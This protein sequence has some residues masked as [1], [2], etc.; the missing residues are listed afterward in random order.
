MQGN[1]NEQFTY[2]DFLEFEYFMTDM[3]MGLLL[4]A[5][6]QDIIS[7]GKWAQDTLS[8]LQ[9][10]EVKRIAAKYLSINNIDELKQAIARF[11]PTNNFQNEKEVMYTAE[12]IQVMNESAE[13]IAENLE[14]ELGKSLLECVRKLT[15]QAIEMSVGIDDNNELYGLVRAIGKK[16]TG[17]EVKHLTNTESVVELLK[18]IYIP[19]NLDKEKGSI[20]FVGS[21]LD[22]SGHCL[23]RVKSS[24]DPHPGQ[25]F[26]V[27]K[28][29][30]PETCNDD[31][32]GAKSSHN[33]FDTPINAQ[34]L[35][36][37]PAGV[38]GIITDP[39]RQPAAS[40]AAYASSRVNAKDREHIYVMYK[41]GGYAGMFYIKCKAGNSACIGACNSKEAILQ[42]T[43]AGRFIQTNLLPEG[44]KRY[45]GK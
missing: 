29:T 8:L 40:S 5:A 19:I 18:A 6:H 35:L 4:E 20:Y 10:N 16:A 45:P 24:N 25:E 34:H 9:L 12:Q 3:D 17:R 33:T 13:Y 42:Q 36:I 44:L 23:A 28:C 7:T 37:K 41:P 27:V 2:Q 30:A 43:S 22:G 11:I 31:C 1:Q 39:R 38:D 14:D 26:L 15:T 21:T 32:Q